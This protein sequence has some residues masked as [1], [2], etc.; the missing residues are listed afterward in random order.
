MARN[1]TNTRTTACPSC[2][3][4][5]L[6][7]GTTLIAF[8]DSTQ[9]IS[10]GPQTPVP[11]LVV[12]VTGIPAEVCDVC[13]EA[14]LDAETTQRVNELVK[15]VRYLWNRFP[16]RLSAEGVV[17]GGTPGEHGG[18]VRVDFREA[19]LSADRVSVRGEGA[20]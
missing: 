10:V 13:G 8:S 12:V 18:V 16:D 3:T 2:P 11:S 7:E 5:Q 1:D 19:G 6:E 17:V 15:D 14:I 20:D 4:G 9:S